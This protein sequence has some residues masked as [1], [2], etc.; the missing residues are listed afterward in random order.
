MLTKVLIF[1]VFIIGGF[2]EAFLEFL[3]QGSE[4]V[5]A[6]ALGSTTMRMSTSEKSLDKHQNSYTL[7]TLGDSQL[8][9]KP[10]RGYGR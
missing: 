10:C 9:R 8:L 3:G 2:P 5:R 6:E 4:P 7:T 1:I